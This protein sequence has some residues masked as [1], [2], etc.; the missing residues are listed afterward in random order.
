MIAVS[1]EDRNQAKM[2]AAD[3]V[4]PSAGRKKRLRQMNEKCIMRSSGGVLMKRWQFLFGI[5]FAAVLVFFIGGVGAKAYTSPTIANI[6]SLGDEE[7]LESFRSYLLEH[8]RECDTSIDIRSF[9][10]PV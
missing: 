7:T 10:I 5:L 8:F 6:E 4:K 9:N 3:A 2:A 1:A